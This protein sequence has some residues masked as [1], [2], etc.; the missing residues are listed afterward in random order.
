MTDRDI[1]QEEK[2]PVFINR[3]KNNSIFN[4]NESG[5]S[6]RITAVVITILFMLVILIIVLY[7]ITKYVK[8]IS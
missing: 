6:M 1:C 2:M 7:Y 8:T 3:N 4:K 5:Q